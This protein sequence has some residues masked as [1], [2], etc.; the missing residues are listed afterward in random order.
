MD[1]TTTTINKEEYRDGFPNVKGWYD[2]LIDDEPIRLYCFIC[3]LARNRKYWVMEDGAKLVGER[4]LWR[5]QA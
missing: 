2:C 4:V 3:E 5:A 1:N